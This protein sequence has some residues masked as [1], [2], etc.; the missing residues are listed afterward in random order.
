M[1]ESHDMTHTVFPQVDGGQRNPREVWR[2]NDSF[3]KH[4]RRVNTNMT[5]TQLYSIQTRKNHIKFMSFLRVM[6]NFTSPNY[7]YTTFK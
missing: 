2:H 5:Q 1:Y 4:V 6:L 7:P 3:I